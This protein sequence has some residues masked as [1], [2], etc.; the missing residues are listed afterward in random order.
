M[1]AGTFTAHHVP[2]L[3]QLASFESF[4]ALLAAHPADRV[5]GACLFAATSA[6]QV[7][8][9]GPFAAHYGFRLPQLTAFHSFGAPFADNS[10]IEVVAAE[11]FITHYVPKLFEAVQT[12]LC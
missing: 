2:R 7:L 5:M 3:S 9:A 8:P 1:A 4:G 11:L 12:N 10:V 6:S